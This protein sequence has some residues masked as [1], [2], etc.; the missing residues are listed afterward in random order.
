VQNQYFQGSKI[1][2][3]EPS[4]VAG[5]ERKKVRKIK[6]PGKGRPSQIEPDHEHDQ[7]I[8]NANLNIVVSKH[9]DEPIIETE[10]FRTNKQGER[11][12]KKESL[13]EV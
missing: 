11:I 2:A 12:S 5:E 7:S 3:V 4:K 9:T 10:D 1:E 6:S 8:S 13:K